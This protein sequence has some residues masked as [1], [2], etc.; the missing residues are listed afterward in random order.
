[1]KHNFSL[2]NVAQVQSD[3]LLGQCLRPNAR[4]PYGLDH[5]LEALAESVEAF[6]AGHPLTKSEH[7]RGYVQRIEE[8]DERWVELISCALS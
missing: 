4:T 3:F 2:R 8:N 5:N 1:M 6:R 7:Y